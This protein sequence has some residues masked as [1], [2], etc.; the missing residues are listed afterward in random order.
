[1]SV[2]LR[3]M[4]YVIAVAE[5]G[6]FQ[7]AAERLHMAQP[8]LSRQIRQVERQLGVDLFHRRPTRLTEPGRVFVASAREVLAEAERAV[9]R[10]R[11]AARAEVGV[12]RVGYGPTTA[13]EEMPRLVAAMRDEHPGVELETRETWDAELEAA[14]RDGALDVGLGRHLPVPPRFAT[15]TLRRE[16]FAVVVGDEHPLAQRATVALRDL[17][18]ETF[19]LFDRRL[20]PDYHDALLAALH[21]TGETFEVWENP[22]PGLRNLNLHSGGF[23][24]LPRSIGA[25]LPGRVACV[26]ISDD[27]PPVEL[28]LVWRPQTAP[29]AVGVLVETARRL[30]LSQG[31]IEPA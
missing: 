20:A 17:R 22:I 14:L 6:S 16:R 18:G 21:S 7:R 13:W 24:L 2:E 26:P 5:E 29:P 25:Q 11:Q 30:A 4:R 12:V 8:P 28:T 15:Q 3:L 27:L 19:Q 9:A 31:W 1:M 10:T 23:M